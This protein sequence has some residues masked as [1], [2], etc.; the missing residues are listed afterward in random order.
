MENVIQKC[1][2][3]ENFLKIINVALNEYVENAIICGNKYNITKEVLIK[4]QMKQSELSFSFTDNEAGF[5]YD[6]FLQQ[7]TERILKSGLLT[8][9][10]LGKYLYFWK[11]GSQIFYVADV[12]FS[13]SARDR[14]MDVLQQSQQTVVKNSHFSI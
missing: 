12:P 13:F 2:I 4:V 5:D 10:L 3:E 9:K 6:S 14:R 1:G 11:N 7:N 8:I